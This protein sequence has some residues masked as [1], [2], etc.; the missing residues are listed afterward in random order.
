MNLPG[1]LHMALGMPT[2][3][4]RKNSPFVAI[5]LPQ[6]DR[7]GTNAACTKCIFSSAEKYRDRDHHGCDVRWTGHRPRHH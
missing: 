1:T 5:W 3:D 4:I 7:M 6:D 2:P